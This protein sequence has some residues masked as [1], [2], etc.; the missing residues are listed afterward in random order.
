MIALRNEVGAEILKSI[1]APE[2]VFPTILM[3]SAFYFLFGITLSR[4]GNNATYFLATYGVF[5]VMGPAIF[6]FGIG[7]ANERERGWLE[8]KR[9]LPAPPYSYVVAKLLAT[10]LFAAAALIPLYLLAGFVGNVRLPLSGWSG[11]YLLHLLSCIPFAC[12]GLSLGFR[13]NSSGAIALSNVIYLGLAVLGGL[14]MPVFVFPDWMQT[15]ALA[16]PTYHFAELA[17]SI[18]GKSNSESLL[19]NLSIVIAMSFAFAGLATLSWL[20]AK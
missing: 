15:V 13:F 10:L 11:L 18:V 3:P 9:L 6:G 17:L 12:I 7:V 14:W 1:R 5:A 8:L 16:T 2:F 20:K 4:G 19:T